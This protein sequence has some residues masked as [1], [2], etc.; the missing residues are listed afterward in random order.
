MHTVSFPS[1]IR[2]GPPGELPVEVQGK[3]LRVLEERKVRRLGGKSEVEI[4]V[5][6]ICATNRDL[7]EEIKKLRSDAG[8]TSDQFA[9]KAGL[10]RIEISRLENGERRPDPNAL[11][12]PV[13][14]GA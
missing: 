4:D 9:R 13:A 1:L 6:V 3:F 5:R 14:D 2:S 10:T 11:V 8:L 7:K 12:K